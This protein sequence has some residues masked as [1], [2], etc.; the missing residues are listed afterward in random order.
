MNE[1][2]GKG[3]RSG[4]GRRGQSTVEY[5]LVLLAFLAVAVALGALWHA[6]RDGRLLRIALEAASHL[7]G[8]D[9]LGSDNDILLF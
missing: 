1:S 9:A 3:T 5:A 4:W 2:V 8:G 7:F 6:G